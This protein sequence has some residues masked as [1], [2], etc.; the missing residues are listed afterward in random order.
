MGD[1]GDMFPNTDEV[2]RNRASS[3]ILQEA[4]TAIQKRG[5]Q[6]VNLDCIVFA[7]RPKLA[8][9][10][11]RIAARIATL[12]DIQQS[13]VGVKAKTGEAVGAVGR[14]EAM[15]AQCVALLQCVSEQ[16]R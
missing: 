2:N 16:E 5:F 11:E 12:L 13:Q 8:P 7:E 4:W 1:I 10:R 15:M 14:E 6:V 3:S 9:F